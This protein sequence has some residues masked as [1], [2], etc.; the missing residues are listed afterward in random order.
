M[1]FQ[2]DAIFEEDKSFWMAVNSFMQNAKC[3]I[4]LISTGERSY[5]FRGNLFISQYYTQIHSEGIHILS[6][7]QSTI[8]C[9]LKICLCRLTAL[10]NQFADLFHWETLL[11]NLYLS[12][13]SGS[14]D[15]VPFN[16]N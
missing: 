15:I 9:H 6:F 1:S 16:V 14:A 7:A 10:E 4:V 11:Y 3:P 12:Y 5:S 8:S 13:D 2:V